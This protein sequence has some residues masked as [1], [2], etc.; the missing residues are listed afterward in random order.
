MFKK[1]RYRS[2]VGYMSRVRN[3]HKLDWDWTEALEQESRS[4]VRSVLRGIG[5]SRQS[6]EYSLLKILELSKDMADTDTPVVTGGPVGPV[7]YCEFSCLYVLREIEG[8]FLVVTDLVFDTTA[9][10]VTTSLSACKTDPK[11]RGCTRTWGCACGGAGTARTVPCAFHC[12]LEQVAAVRY[13]LKEDPAWPDVPLFPSAGGV[14]V[15]MDACVR[16]IE[17]LAEAA[18]D[19]LRDE[20]GERRMGGHS[21]RISGSRFLARLGIPLHIIQGLARWGSDVVLHYIQDAP[22][23]KLTV[24]Y[25]DALSEQYPALAQAPSSGSAS[26]GSG[27]RAGPTTTQTASLRKALHSLTDSVQQL[28]EREAAFVSRVDALENPAIKTLIHNLDT[29]SLH[30]ALVDGPDFLPVEWRSRCGWRFGQK[31]FARLQNIPASM[32]WDKICDNCLRHER[33]TRADSDYENSIYAH[34]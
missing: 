2:F 24:F 26:S 20:S 3:V 31:R 16:T 18:G 29:G 4:A 32:P 10:E 23:C 8:S 7:R 17:F 13:L 1:G 12:A 14:A 15:S 19:S 11:A 30:R 22:L 9:E 34:G 21:H 27:T 5:P 33:R 28:L 25:R 6:S